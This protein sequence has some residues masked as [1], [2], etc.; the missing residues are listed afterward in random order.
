M[1]NDPTLNYQSKVPKQ[2]KSTYAIAKGPAPLYGTPSFPHH[3][4][5]L[6]GAK[7][8]QGLLK[9]IEIIALPG[10]KFTLLEQLPQNVF[11]IRTADYPSTTPLYVDGR[12]LQT[13][14]GS[15]PERE[16]KLPSADSILKFM[17][18]LLGARYFWG[19]NWAEGIPLMADLYPQLP[20]DDD[21]LCRGVDCSGLL[22]QAT[23]GFTPRNTAQL[24]N[25]GTRIEFD[26][27]NVKPLDMMVWRGH[28]I[29]VLDHDS[30]IESA[31][32]KGVFVSDIKE[33]VNF[34]QDKLRADSKP[35]F[36]R[37]WHPNFLT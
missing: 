35:F 28:V 10:T 23:G 13:A 4:S 15:T 2:K 16:K 26:F 11:E 14:T 5:S 29:F 9:Q 6:D 1:H 30:V 36:F 25:Y 19:G 12:F 18:S 27:E 34:F 20:L 3:L 7:D 22:Y 32:G 33:R 37:R 17:Q 8:H 21:L 24:C 31:L